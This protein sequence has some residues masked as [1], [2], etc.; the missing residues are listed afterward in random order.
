M[1]ERVD[2]K[3]G[4]ISCQFLVDTD[5]FGTTRSGTRTRGSVIA[6]TLV[7]RTSK[8]NLPTSTLAKSVTNALVGWGEGDFKALDSIPVTLQGTEF[9][10]AVL[11]AMRNIPSGKT[12]SYLELAQK[13]GYPNAHRA[14]ASVCAKNRI[15][16]IIPCHRVVKSDGSVGKYFY[17]SDVKQALLEFESH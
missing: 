2:V 11:K 14:V 8:A 4:L 13:S 16:L 15:P 7:A 3:A 5:Q 6:L 1:I 17:G 12:L 9:Q 10:V